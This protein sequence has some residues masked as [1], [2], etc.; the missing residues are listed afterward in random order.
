MAP[1]HGNKE[2]MYG[3]LLSY[4]IP[5]FGEGW[6]YLEL[7]YREYSWARIDWT[8][9]CVVWV[10]LMKL[11]VYKVLRNTCTEVTIDVDFEFPISRRRR[12]LFRRRFSVFNPY[13]MWQAPCPISAH[14]R[15]FQST[16]SSWMTS[17]EVRHK[18]IAW[19]QLGFIIHDRDLVG[20]P[21]VALWMKVEDW[22]S[23]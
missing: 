1:T 14:K 3:V 7:S 15:P 8:F 21:S 2:Q 10:T 23:V 17:G 5:I 19:A 4:L 6:D 16:G 11:W 22:W 12:I 20:Q 13:S 9:Q 18:N